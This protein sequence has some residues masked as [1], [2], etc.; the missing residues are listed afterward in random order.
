MQ[1]AYVT[2]NTG[3]NPDFWNGAHLVV[4]GVLTDRVLSGS[5]KRNPTTI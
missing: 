1:Y 2:G 5:D 3:E 4:S